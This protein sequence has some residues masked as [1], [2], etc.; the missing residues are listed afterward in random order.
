MVKNAKRHNSITAFNSYQEEREEVQES[1]AANVPWI[2]DAICQSSHLPTGVRE[3]SQI[4]S[5]Q[6]KLNNLLGVLLDHS[7]K[8]LQSKLKSLMVL[9]I[10]G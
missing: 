3:T 1:L 6:P 2:V 7:Q 9:P 4:D 10:N 5:S 8:L